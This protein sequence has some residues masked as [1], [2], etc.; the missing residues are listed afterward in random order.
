M[1]S[2]EQRDVQAV[3]AGIDE[4][5]PTLRERAQETEDLRKLPDAN[6]KALEDI[7]FFKLLQPEQWGGLQCDPT[8]F[9]EAVRRLASACGSTG[10]VAGIIGVHNWHLALFDQQAQEDVWGEDTA[11]RISSSYAPMGAGVVTETGDGYIVN[12]SWNWSSGCDHATWAFLGGPVIK[13]GR[14]V[15]FGSFLIPISDYKIDDVWN[16]VGLRGTGSNTVVVKDAFVPKHRFLSYK[17]MNDGT[18]GGYE[19]NTAPVYKMPWGTIHPTTISTPIVGMAYG[20]YDA[21]VEHQGKRVRAA[22]AGEKAKDD[23][24]AKIRIAEAAS[25]IDAAWRQLS[26]NVAEEYALLVAGEEI[27]FELRA[28]A[29]RD[30]VRATGRSI[31]SIDRLF[32]A[33]GATALSND[34]PV[35]RFWR[36]AHAGRVH[37]ANDPE[38]A[39]LIF[40]NNEFGLPPADTMV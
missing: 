33:S 30:Q 29:R 18:A 15:D 20:A 4:L 14:P 6:V 40:G 37:A 7:G 35:Q 13:D 11:V 10:W 31:A 22:F 12:G 34:A 1:T 27:P 39:Y 25:D 3:L 2:I 5:L 19:T 23:P 9:Y 8:V 32:E 21:H 36:D 16:V 17:A 26:G 24:F 28:R 38:R